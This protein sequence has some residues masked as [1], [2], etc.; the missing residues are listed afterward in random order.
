M[1]DSHHHLWNFTEEEFSWLEP[2][3]QRTFLSSDLEQTLSD[4]GITGTVAVQA[5]CNLQENDFLLEQAKQTSLIKG[6]VGWVD[7]TKS[8]R[9]EQLEILSDQPLIK[10]V[11]EITQ[12]TPDEQFLANDKFN[13][14]IQL[15]I[16]KDLNYDLLIFEDQLEVASQFVAKH[17]NLSIVLDHCAKPSIQ[18]HLFPKEWAKGIKEIAQHPN[19]LCKLSGLP[20]EIRDSS[21]CNSTILRPYFD[22][23]IEAFGADRIMFGSDWPVSLGVTP[24]ADWLNC[25]KELT[26]ELSQ[27]EQNAIYTNNASLFYKL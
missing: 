16:E 6:I 1:I 3:L 21:A 12:G 27:S 9:E 5:R 14:G 22:T 15:L 13:Q 25:V 2:S 24:Y 26:N 10:G 20:T 11:R 19:L 18:H 17:P 23:V 7:L 4:T 8:N